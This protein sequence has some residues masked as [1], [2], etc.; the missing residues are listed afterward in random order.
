MKP[1]ELSILSL[2]IFII[3]AVIVFFAWERFC[4]ARNKTIEDDAKYLSDCADALRNQIEVYR[5]VDHGHIS[6][7]GIGLVVWDIEKKFPGIRIF[8][9]TVLDMYVIHLYSRFDTLCIK[10]KYIE[11]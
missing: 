4:T 9:D 1:W 3:I 5:K 11:D 8:D 10:G 7:M 2:L 6:M